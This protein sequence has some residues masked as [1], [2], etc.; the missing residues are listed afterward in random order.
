MAKLT[1]CKTCG[2]EVAASA[3]VCPGC[4]A[5][6]KMG[7]FSKIVLGVVGL[8]VIVGIAGVVFKPSPE[9]KA[10]QTSQKLQQLAAMSTVNIDFQ[11]ASVDSQIEAN[12]GNAIT[13]NVVVQGVEK[14]ENRYK[15]T[16]LL[17]NAGVNV[18]GVFLY[19]YPRNPQDEQAI[20]NLKTLE[21]IQVKGIISGTLLGNLELDPAILAMSSPAALSQSQPKAEAP[22]QPK[23]EVAAAV[24]AAAKADF[25]TLV[26]KP[27]SDALEHPALKAKFA[28][29]LGAA[30]SDFADRLN[31]SSGIE[32][33]GNYYVGAGCAPHLCSSDESIFSIDKNTGTVVAAMLMGGKE[34]QMFGASSPNEL[35]PPLLQ[36]YK[37]KG[38]HSV[39]AQASRSS[40]ASVQSPETRAALDFAIAFIKAHI[41]ECG[42]L[43]FVAR[44]NPPDFD[45][46][47]QILD[48]RVA[49]QP[50]NAP[51]DIDKLNG[52]EWRGR[53]ILLAKAAR[54]VDFDFKRE[55]DS[56]KET[57]EIL[58][59]GKWNQWFDPMKPPAF[60][61]NIEKRRGEWKV[62][63]DP[64]AGQ[65]EY[66]KPVDCTILPAPP[67]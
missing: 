49:V 55:P 21:T 8:I 23:Q 37:E 5:K 4:G 56:N 66:L 54:N 34:I 12:K 52:L 10:K 62:V 45:Y 64:F 17:S 60:V 24:P 53:M 61:T 67:K 9:E 27:P 38:G 48:P 32:V 44:R 19:L 28:S 16:S 2:K 15:V 11:S 14:L 58:R 33:N 63:P 26:G 40:N 57:G 50:T 6:L 29:L 35:P 3:K 46:V 51:S 65:G 30:L 18:K 13:T 20:A 47:Y 36:W 31:V 1:K 7:M 43:R 25:S 42:K 41:F 22:A 39:N 59:F